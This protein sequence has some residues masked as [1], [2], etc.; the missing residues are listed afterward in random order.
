VSQQDADPHRFSDALR[1]LAR[2]LGAADWQLGVMSKMQRGP[3]SFTVPVRNGHRTDMLQRHLLCRA[4]NS[5][6]PRPDGTCRD[7]G[8]VVE[9]DAPVC[10]PDV[11]IP[12]RPDEVEP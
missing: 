8:A 2:S 1:S 5:H 9:P 11:A 3:V 4:T 10:A 6:D 12:V 7:C